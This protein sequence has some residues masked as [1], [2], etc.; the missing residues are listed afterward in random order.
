[1]RKYGAIEYA[2]KFARKIVQESWGEV[3]KLLPASEAKEKLNAFAK[4]LIERKI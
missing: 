1:M 4:F 2:K 3:E